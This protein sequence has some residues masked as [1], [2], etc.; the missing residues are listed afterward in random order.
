MTDQEIRDWLHLIHFSVRHANG[1][2][3]RTELMTAE[4]VICDLLINANK[5]KMIPEDRA[6]CRR[7]LEMLRSK[8]IVPNARLPRRIIPEY[9][10]S[11]E[12]I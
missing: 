11:A 9:E 1:K 8:E 12:A 3:S 2:G 6:I 7:A 4:Q 5:D 10:I